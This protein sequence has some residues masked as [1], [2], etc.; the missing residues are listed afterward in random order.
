M[1]NKLLSP[2]PSVCLIQNE[3]Q[4]KILLFVGIYHPPGSQPQFLL[5]LLNTDEVIIVED[6]II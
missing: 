3:N 6:F 4:N 1:L 2:L 5:D